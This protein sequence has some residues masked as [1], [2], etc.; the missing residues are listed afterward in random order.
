MSALDGDGLSTPRPAAFGIRLKE[1]RKNYEHLPARHGLAV[2]AQ[3]SHSEH[4]A[5]DSRPKP[6]FR[7]DMYR[8]FL[9]I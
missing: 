8:G 2:S 7:N 5:C 4:P 1:R 6:A 9:Y 3:A